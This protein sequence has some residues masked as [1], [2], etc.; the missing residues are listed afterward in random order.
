MQQESNLWKNE[1]QILIWSV[2]VIDSDGFR[3]NVGIILSNS[4]GKV[5]WARRVG[6][7][8]WQFPQGGIRASETPEQALYRELNE[9]TGLQPEH[10]RIVGV[11]RRWLTYRLP[12]NLI[13]RDKLPLCIGQ[14]QLWYM[15]ELLGC[16]EDICLDK[17]DKPEFDHWKWVSYWYPLEQVVSFKKP[18]YQAALNELAPLLTTQAE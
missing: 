2:G 7:E 4:S 15:L 6:K 3:Q 5:F 9:E 1:I 16:D 18:V 11:T 13:R 14:K 8:V 17:T 12:Q 10:V